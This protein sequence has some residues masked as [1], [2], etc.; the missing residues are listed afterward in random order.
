MIY[1][2]TKFFEKDEGQELPDGV[3]GFCPVFGD[4]ESAEKAA[5]GEVPIIQLLNAEEIK[6]AR[7]RQE[8]STDAQVG[9]FDNG[10]N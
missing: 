7:R 1:L 5:G 9:G 4:Q 3:I 6:E 10:P 8:L 2:V